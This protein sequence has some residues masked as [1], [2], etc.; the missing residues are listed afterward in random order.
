MNNSDRRIDFGTPKE[1]GNNH[2]AMLP[3]GFRTRCISGKS[4]FKGNEAKGRSHNISSTVIRY[5]KS[6]ASRV[7]AIN[8]KEP[9]TAPASITRLFI[10]PISVELIDPKSAD[11][12]QKTSW[13]ILK[14]VSPII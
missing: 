13:K 6:Q 14:E 10:K 9:G 3:S 2:T 11:Y 1:I 8:G 7:I 4:R 12:D 5:A